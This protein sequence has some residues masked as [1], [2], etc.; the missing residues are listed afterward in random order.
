MILVQQIMELSDM[1]L[2]SNILNTI[3]DIKIKNNFKI[4]LQFN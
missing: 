2:N 1:H 4:F 3:V